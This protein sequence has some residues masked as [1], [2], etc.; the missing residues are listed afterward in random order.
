MSGMV[1]FGAANLSS[2][3][4]LVAGMNNDWNIYAIDA[5]KG[6]NSGN[7]WLVSQNAYSGIQNALTAASQLVS[8]LSL[9]GGYSA[10]YAS[11]ASSYITKAQNESPTDPTGW[12]QPCVYMQFA[13][14]VSG[15]VAYTNS[16]Y[17]A[18]LQ[19][20]QQ[21]QA[22]AIQVLTIPGGHIGLL[23]VAVLGWQDPNRPIPLQVQGMF[24]GTGNLSASLTINSVTDTG[25]SDLFGNP[26]YDV[27]VTSTGTF[28][29]SPASK[30]GN[31]GAG[32]NTVLCGSTKW[33]L[34]IYRFVDSEGLRTLFP[35][36]TPIST[37]PGGA[38]N[39]PVG[40]T[41]PTRFTLPATTAPAGAT[42]TAPP[43]GTSSTGKDVLIAVAVTAGLAAVGAGVLMFT[44]RPKRRL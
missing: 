24:N 23:T 34:G 27:N 28:F 21:A 31:Y 5:S 32:Y 17:Q 26:L 1:G 33:C 11:Q 43:A 40:V 29:G 35:P 42:A 39:A 22:A 13:N 44:R 41:L 36:T 12:N 19:Q 20:I 30:A 7:C 6:M 8:T 37:L 10:S 4:A 18:L 25:K 15:A 14:D 38:T 3:S 9:F 16:A 2:M